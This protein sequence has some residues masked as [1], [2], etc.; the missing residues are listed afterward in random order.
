MAL[1]HWNG[2]RWQVAPPPFGG[3]DP[4]SGFSATAWNDAWAVG[5]YG[6]GGNKVTKVSHPLAAHWNGH[7]WQMTPLPNPPGNGNSFTLISVTAARPDYVLALGESQH[8]GFQGYNGASGSAPVMYFVRWDG[9]SWRVMP[10]S[11]P[12]IY[13]GFPGISA[14]RDG[15]A[16]AVGWCREDDFVVHLTA[17]GWATAPHPRDSWWTN[18]IIGGRHLRPPSCSPQG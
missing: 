17:D 9:Q 4:F 1:R 11:G 12:G 3:T 5:S 2:H 15:S 14:G 7:R 10:G 18:P 6:Q 16:W 8:L 13:E